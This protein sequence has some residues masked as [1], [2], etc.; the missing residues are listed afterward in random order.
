M[1]CIPIT[2][3][4]NQEAI[5][6]I[7]E[8]SR[9]ADIIE[10][11]L[12]YIKDPDLDALLRGRTRPVIVTNRSKR[13]GG[14]FQGTELERM[15]LLQK[16]ISLD[17]EYVDIELGS[18]SKFKD[19]GR[20]KL[21]VSYHNFNETPKNITQIHND[22]IKSGASIVKLVTFARDITDN[23]RIFELLKAAHFPTIAFCMGE[24][25]QISRILA[26][27]FGGMLTFASL[28]KGK[29]SAPGQLSINEL[30][31]VYHVS[32]IDCNTS[33]Y[34]IIGNPVSHSVSPHIHNASFRAMAI[35]AV[36]L[37]FMV[38]DVGRFIES[39]KDIG[40]KGLS[41]TIPHKEEIIKHLDEIDPLANRIG[42]VNTVINRDGRLVGYNT[43]C[44]SASDALEEI[45]KGK[46]GWNQKVVIIGAGGAARAIAFGLKEKGAG[47]TI[48]NRTN[49]RGLNLS[50]EV[51]CNYARFNEIEGI[52]MDVLINTT[53]VG[54]F[55]NVDES[56]VP[57]T[58]LKNGIVVFDIVYN[59]ID[60]KL[61]KEAK[62]MGCIIINGVEMFLRQAALQFELFTGQK[63]PVPLMERI[64]KERLLR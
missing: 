1:I 54:M 9:I 35:N 5:E 57:P 12:D 24:L 11:R 22:L 51:G 8:A 45:L 7:K 43:D 47:I 40:F 38:E 17:P 55:P 30:R 58:I 37:P 63:A 13:D 46:G 53:S 42:A 6:D 41:V 23:A 20:T 36:Y 34:G 26:T 49:N 39:F 2:A 16:A 31:D 25:G 19:L 14:D 59:P 62:A 18:V 3:H 4:T 52:D 28:A 44:P 56:P 61:L 15:A 10:L 27:K 33:I 21:I 50:K 32:E 48:I 29:E 64:I 60:T